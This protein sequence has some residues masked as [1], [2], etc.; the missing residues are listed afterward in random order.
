MWKVP[1]IKQESPL[2]GW[3]KGLL[4]HPQG[5]VG[6]TEYVI[7]V[8]IGQMDFEDVQAPVDGIDQASLRASR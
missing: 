1:G 6:Q 7:R 8:V 4:F 3:P 5:V 2:A